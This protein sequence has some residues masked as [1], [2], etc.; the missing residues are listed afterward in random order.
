MIFHPL[1]PPFGFP[2]GRDPDFR[3]PRLVRPPT[4]RD[5]IPGAAFALLLAVFGVTLFLAPVIFLMFTIKR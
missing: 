5:A 1:G 2:M 4:G 3:K